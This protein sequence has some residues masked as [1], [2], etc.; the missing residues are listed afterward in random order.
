MYGFAEVLKHLIEVMF[1]ASLIYST[2]AGRVLNQAH[3]GMHT[4]E[5]LDQPV[6]AEDVPVIIIEDV[7]RIPHFHTTLFVKE[8]IP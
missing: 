3:S 6:T 7:C 1:K 4:N 8:L 5:Q 2:Q